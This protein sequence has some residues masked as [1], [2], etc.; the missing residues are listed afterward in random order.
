MRAF[1]PL[2]I[3]ILTLL[4][5]CG[6][7]RGDDEGASAPSDS[8]D[9]VEQVI[10]PEPF[11][12]MSDEFEAQLK[13]GAES[14]EFQAELHRLMDIIV[15]SLY[16]NKEVF[17][18]EL[19]SNAADALDKVRFLSL[20]DSSILDVN[21][22]LDIQ[23]WYDAERA[24]ISIKDTGIGMTKL[25]LI[26]DL[27][28][29]A[30]SGTSNFVEALAHGTD[31]LSQIGQFGVGFYAAYLVADKVQVISKHTD[32]DQYIWESSASG[33]F[34]V[35]KDPRGNTLGRGTEVVLH[36]KEESRHFA[37]WET[38]YAQLSNQTKFIP[39]QILLYKGTDGEIQKEQG[40]AEKE[41][42]FE[43]VDLDASDEADMRK[44]EIDE[45]T[46]SLKDNRDNYLGINP[47]SPLWMKPKD[48]ITEAEYTRL[49]K[50]IA[51]RRTGDSPIAYTHFKA[52]GDV[53]FTGILFVYDTPP[54]LLQQ[55]N[56]PE[57]ADIS[58]YVRKVLLSHDPPDILPRYMNFVCGIVDS[59]ALGVNVN[60]ESLQES[61]AMPVI[62][63]KLQSKVF[64]MLSKLAKV[65]DENE[66]DEYNKF[67][68]MYSDSLKL[69]SVEDP[70]NSVKLQKL[71]RYKTSKS[72]GKWRSFAQYRE[73]MKEW[74]KDMYYIAGD[75]LEEC[76]S[77]PFLDIFKEKDIEVIFCTDMLD[78]YFFI[79][80]VP[81]LELKPMDI[82]Q[83][84]I[85]LGD[86]D[87]KK[88]EK[89]LIKAYRKKFAPLKEYL[90]GLYQTKFPTMK[91]RVSSR[92]G[93][94]P[95][96]VA[97]SA[98]GDSAHRER[99]YK[100]YS[101]DRPG[102]AS[103][104]GRVLYVNPRHILV[105]TLLDLVVKEE[106]EGSSSEVD[107]ERVSNLAWV[108][109]DVA[110]AS[111][112][113]DINTDD[114]SERMLNL[115]YSS[116]N[117]EDRGELLPKMEV[118][119]EDTG[120]GMSDVVDSN[121]L[122]EDL[123]HLRANHSE[124]DAMLTK[125]EDL[126]ERMS[127]SQEEIAKLLNEHKDDEDEDTGDGMS[128]VEDS[129]DLEEDL[130]HLRANHSEL[131][132]MLTKQ[133]DLAERVSKSQEEIAKLLNEDK[134][135]EDVTILNSEAFSSEL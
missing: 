28:T 39:F 97:S 134:D 105:E 22:S 110:T 61:S 38:L 108:L 115:M 130:E 85:T 5:T 83:E 102:L 7:V 84:G 114:F 20:S 59:D 101:P 14:F 6:W 109:H 94:S 49:Y 35:S 2:I 132:A 21:P 111:S 32:D 72:D 118:P 66:G 87:D 46:A 10:V 78:E 17:I 106:E 126:A 41:E 69:G 76:E 3:F 86:S 50:S 71:L 88:A 90:E 133:E 79:Q 80:H 112:G 89:R 81:I 4:T 116:L 12:T 44:L 9:H 53:E 43:N 55:A 128:D 26:E 121:D 119:D 113:Y 67:Y 34:T 91:V 16:R 56:D 8:V 60:R 129:N 18:R 23:V 123:E 120:D 82:S 122:E 95:A 68:E 65:S 19:I 30:K 131:D 47:G 13:S 36:L 45:E 73:N 100:Y 11:N 99:I 93:S 103:S 75:S 51:K 57:Y 25:D 58:L 92:P 107:P 42:D 33:V 96:L 70:L 29:V 124:L 135:D 1:P 48:E 54:K 77:S 127:K 27:G 40:D 31:A 15:H 24:Q 117:V 74:Q 62:T 98:Q 63:K 104:M 125:Q 64:E 37:N 52:E